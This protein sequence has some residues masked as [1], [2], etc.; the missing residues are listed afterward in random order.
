MGKPSPLEARKSRLSDEKKALLGRLLQ[1]A[2][3]PAAPG[4]PLTGPAAPRPRQT[5]SPLSFSQQRLWFLSA[6]EPHSSAYHLIYGVKLGGPLHKE[7]LKRSLHAVVQRHEILRTVFG[8]EDG[9]AYQ[10]VLDSVSIPLEE[11]DLRSLPPS[12]REEAV[13]M[14]IRRLNRPFD[15]ERGPHLRTALLVLAEEEHLLLLAFHHIITDGWSHHRF[16]R[17]LLEAYQ[18]YTEGKEKDLPPL[19]MQYGDYA[20]WQRRRHQEEGFREG[21]RYWKDKLAG[22][23]A[24]LPLPTDYPRPAEQRYRGGKVPF[25][26]DRPLAERLRRLAGEEH[27]TAFM[28]LMAA[29]Q[30][31]LHRTCGEEDLCVGTTISGRNRKELE[32]LIGFFVNTLV[33][34]S[35]VA[36]ERPFRQLLRQVK[37]DS[38]A[39]YVH[40]DVPFE[41]LV[42]ELGVPRSLSY[43][44]LIQVM[45]TLQNTPSVPLTWAGLTAE[46][47][48]VDTGSSKFDLTLEMAEAA[49]GW[50]GT[51]EYNL[52]LFEEATIRRMS[53]HFLCLLA[54]IADAPDTPVNALP[55]LTAQEREL[56]LNVWSRAERAEDGW[57]EAHP[58]SCRL[59]SM[60]TRQGEAQ[61]EQPAVVEAS[62]RMLTYGM[63]IR[64]AERLAGRLRSLGLAPGGVAAVCLDR[65]AELVISQLAV[66]MA[67]GAYLPIDPA[68]PDERLAFITADSQASLLLTQRSF[69]SRL[70]A[71]DTK[72]VPVDVSA[73]LEG[74]FVQ[75]GSP[76]SAPSPQPGSGESA[77]YVIYTSGTTGKPKGTLIPHEAVVNFMQWYRKESAL[78]PGDRVCFSSSIGFD[79]S[80]AEIFGALVSGASLW[81]PPEAYRLEPGKLRD[82]MIGQG[83][84]FAFLPTPLAEQLVGLFWPPEAP[85][86]RLFA[87]GDKWGIKLPPG[88]PFQ[89]YDLYG[90][91][92]CTIATTWRII[93]PERGGRELP[94]HIGRPIANALTYIVDSNMNPVPVGLHGE[95]MIGGRGVGNG[96]LHRKAL[97]REKFA[98]NPFTPGGG[99]RL[100][101]SG[102]IARYLPDGKIQFLGRKDDQVKLRGFRIELSEIQS[103]LLA[104]DGIKE[105]AVILREDSPGDKRITAYVTT[106]A[107]RGAD[108]DHLRMRLKEQLPPYMVPSAI[109]V[110]DRLPLTPSGKIDRRALP[111]P[112]LTAAADEG[113]GE[114]RNEVEAALCRIWAE[115]LVLDKVSIHH[116]YFEIGGDSIKTMMLIS[117][118]KSAGM[119]LTQKQ[120]FQHQTIAELSR[121][122]TV[123]TPPLENGSG[124]AGSGD[125]ARGEEAIVSAEPP[126]TKWDFPLARLNRADLALVPGLH[127]QDIED[128]YPLTPLQD[129]MLDMLVQRPGRAQFF[130]NMVMRF[131][132]K[133]DPQKMTEAWQLVGNHYAITRTAIAD[134]G[135]PV[136][137]QL[138][139]RHARIPVRFCDWRGW[140]PERQQE[141]LRRYQEQQLLAS[142][143]A[144]IRRP[145]TYEVMFATLGD[146]DHQL[147]M[148]CSYLL[149]DGWSHFIVLIHVLKCYYHLLQGKPYELPPVQDYGRY[150]AWL[151]TR[152]LQEAK[153]YWETDLAGISRATPLIQYA[154]GSRERK[155]AGFGK[156]AIRIEPE[157]PKAVQELA[158][159]FRVTAN[160]LFQL[161][162]TLLLA[163][164]TGERDVLF[165]V[166]SSGR[167]AA[168][169]GS[170][171]LV[172][173]A[174]N[175]LPL[176]IQLQDEESVPELL[177]RIQEKQLQLAQRDYTP[178]K[179]IRE[180]IGFAD[181]EPLF[182]SYMIFQNLHSFFETTSGVDWVTSLPIENEYHKALAIFNSGTPLRVDVC[183]DGSG[184]EVYMTYLRAGFSDESVR[185]MLSDLRETFLGLLAAPYQPVRKWLRQ[186]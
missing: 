133:L 182:E 57:E 128:A 5:R 138:K 24:L 17:E 176:R 160:V 55:M 40:Q 65:S 3:D 41:L 124:S 67:G 98:A 156:Q 79:L 166:M 84:S 29:F 108:P 8:S 20:R 81:I 31:L 56:L 39:A 152:D 19:G 89:V 137:V 118:A 141:E 167:Q 100:Y 131:K 172:G 170:E 125:P 12:G 103:V 116:N 37:E 33:L 169:D 102:D 104:Q 38:L 64:Q 151:R 149:M 161:A 69:L 32:P 180:W 127:P 117:R 82:W 91:T 121:V 113:H 110:M 86:R 68:L 177:G 144:Y 51:L 52:D 136:P 14:S 106:A 13:Q 15:L 148:S 72:A 165:G 120:V 76:D 53:Q 28:L 99:E 93:E 16:G 43:T 157:R 123:R 23:P 168:Y 174:I 164:Y 119:E 181:G 105:A 159:Q 60:V 132:D 58:A 145:S 178:L 163:R 142:D 135:L 45:F 11:E 158:G 42:D 115:L 35:Q 143:L 122:V 80:V 140:E 30:T 186:P 7:A 83:I 46:S 111:K 22:A 4:S 88:L 107:G 47:L 150:A 114:P 59:E 95:L 44:P 175:T 77:A 34:R 6:L 10:E 92:E 61:P 75:E 73:C 184:F 94:A 129:Y 71:L 85:L 74:E 70:G 2:G 1:G 96:Y 155:E 9:T 90:P 171:E 66:M 18:A 134:L 49:G 50:M 146:N 109:V 36:P 48:E 183:V 179:S 63:L 54:G 112:V 130:V 87:G 97:T 26:V 147:V 27:A 154:P 101:R 78:S 126:V 139:R 185:R 62:G 153:A 173:P 25:V 162:W 21:L